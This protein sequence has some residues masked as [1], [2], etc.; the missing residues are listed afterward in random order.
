MENLPLLSYLVLR[1]RCSSCGGA[2]GPRYPL[3]EAL[4][5]LL[6]VLVV[7]RFGIG[8]ESAAA[9]ILTWRLITLAAI[10]LE[11]GLLPDAV[12]LPGLWLGLSPAHW[13]TD[14][15]SAILGAVLGYLGLRGLFHL[16]WLLTGK[17]GHGIRRLQATRYGSRPGWAS[18][19]CPRSCCSPR[20]PG[21]W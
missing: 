14:S 21:S 9:L 1:G 6:S 11:T 7:Q 5:A 20:A 10:D 3:V 19:T 12:T 4:T 16:F 15:H 18:R 2:I 13:F 17:G 8:W